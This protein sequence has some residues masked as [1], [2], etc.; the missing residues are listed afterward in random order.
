LLC[1]SEKFIGFNRGAHSALHGFY[2]PYE[3][4]C[5]GEKVPVASL[6]RPQLARYNGSMGRYQLV[7]FAARYQKGFRNHVVPLTDVPGLLEKFQYFGCYSTYFIFADEL[8]TYLGAQTAATPSVAGYDG[9][10]WAPYLPID[11]DHPDLLPALECARLLSE[12]FLDRWRIDAHGLQI[13]FSGAKGFHFMLDTRLFGKL[14]PA[15]NWPMLFDALRRHIAQQLPERLREVVDLSIK[16]RMR[17]L[18]LPNTV[19]EK[20][21]LYKTLLTPADL[22]KLSADEIRQ[23]ARQTTPLTVTEE[24]G[25]LSQVAVAEN[26]TA[27]ELLW[28]VQRQF[29]KLTRRPFEYRFNRANDLARLQFP[30]A[31]AQGIWQR[32]IEPGYRNNCAIRLA[33]ELRLLGLSAEECERKLLEWNDRNR[34]ELS[35]AELGSVV[36]SAYLHR[37]P[38]RYS[39]HDA[40]LR[41]YCPLKDERD[42]QALVA[43]KSIAP[44][45]R[46]ARR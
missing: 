34:V 40:L 31:G 17:L 16:D 41:R 14:A 15:R 5:V 10:V 43:G 32:H 3:S 37:F 4:G 20:S 18:R 27:G 46:K 24:S 33:S 29:K 30:C 8:L 12:L 22:A 25:L 6:R 11:L 13:Y 26:P 35:G 1:V 7:D 21:Q 9:K 42:C 19:H 39:C 44:A 2:A 45:A 38:Y 23:R 36:R 28:R